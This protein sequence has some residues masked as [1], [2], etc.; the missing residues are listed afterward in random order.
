MERK[1]AARVRKQRWY[2]RFPRAVPV[3]LF[4]LV[5]TI[6]ALSVYAIEQVE[7][8][9]SDAQ[10]RQMADKIASSIERLANANSAYL[11]AG[12]ALISVRGELDAAAFHEFSQRLNDD[13]TLR[14]GV[15]MGWAEEWQ[16]SQLPVLAARLRREGSPPITVHPASPRPNVL[17]V[18]YV[19]P[20][21]AANRAAFGFDLYSEPV[22]WAAVEAAM[23]SGQPTA[24]GSVPLVVVAGNGQSAFGF[25]IFMPVM[26]N[27]GSGAI[28]GVL[29]RAFNG[30]QF[31]EAA[32]A[33]EPLGGY[34]VV[35]FDN[36]GPSKKVLARVGAEQVGARPLVRQIEIA[37]RPVELNI[38][39]P[40]AAT[41][42]NLSLLTLMFG[43][44][45]AALMLV[46]ARLVTQH[47]AEDRAALAWFE[48]QAS[49]RNSLTRE[50]NHRVKNTLANVLSIV[51]LTRR[52]TDNM[53]EFVTG[54]IG[55]VRALS[56]THDLL[57]QSEWGSTPVRAVMV[58]ELA[59]YVQDTDRAVDLRGPDVELAPN[60]ALSL[61]LA[62]H[63]LAT[64]A[65]K[66]GALSI[67]GGRVG[68]T[69]EMLTE[70][71]ARIEWV[72]IGGPAVPTERR[73]GFGTELI[74]KIVAHELKNP[75]ELQ[76]S[77]TGVRCVLI[78]PVR[79]PAA[80]LLRE[81][82]AKA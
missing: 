51:A 15:A 39:P 60:D 58:A 57:T 65:S 32:L 61:G 47:A 24:S 70:K 29:A 81:R 4:L 2:L 48:E 14:A 55:R 53:D 79:P 69:W 1:V 77:A 43:M 21:V 13:D 41:L 44:L 3:A 82:D 78:V 17:P 16:K 25:S 67:P 68:I 49:I 62:V 38:L 50:L 80:F 22:R 36:V 6:T 18:V 26:R 72:E 40:A 66:Y 52:R 23:A 12:A 20:A 73:R 34:G 54:L 11:R 56:A 63:E 10:Q 45:V 8:Q 37:H 59:P 46:V 71:L 27:D 42:S 31:A 64:N 7:T 28:R 76:F 35:L 30:Q 9:R 5:S 19:E 74:E 33:G 75:V